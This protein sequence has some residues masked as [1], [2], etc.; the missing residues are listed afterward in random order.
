MVTR[1]TKT[2][3][4]LVDARDAERA[5]HLVLAEKERRLALERERTSNKG[6]VTRKINACRKDMDALEALIAEGVVTVTVQALPWPAYRRLLKEHPPRPGDEYDAELGY[7]EET[8]LRGLLTAATVDA[9]DHAGA[10]YA[11]DFDALL[12]DETGLDPHSTLAWFRAAMS[13]QTRPVDLS[14]R[15]RAS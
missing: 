13:L 5:A 15:R 2:V 12:D 10:P 1:P 14:P 6:P 3:Q 9:V 4:I 8:F 7:N 11:L